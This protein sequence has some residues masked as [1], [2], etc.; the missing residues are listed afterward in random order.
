MEGIQ[1]G[2]LTFSVSIEHPRLI[3][4]ILKAAHFQKLIKDLC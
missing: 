3:Q 2:K 4:S 1:L